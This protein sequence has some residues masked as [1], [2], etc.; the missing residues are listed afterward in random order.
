MKSTK[1]QDQSIDLQDLEDKLV[2][3]DPD[4]YPDFTSD[5]PLDELKKAIKE[6]LESGDSGVSSLAEY[7][8]VFASRQR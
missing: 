6:G 4:K 1:T 5:W 3:L 7:R 2:N 8:K